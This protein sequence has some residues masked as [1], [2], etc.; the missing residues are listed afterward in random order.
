MKELLRKITPR[1]LI[2]IKHYI[3]I[4]FHYHRETPALAKELSK[5]TGIPYLTLWLEMNM[6]I[7]RFVTPDEYK[8]YRFYDRSR[9]SRN[10]IITKYRMGH[11]E[12]A[13]NQ[14]RS[15]VKSSILSEK[16]RYYPV[17][18][19]YIGRQWL[20]APDA[21]DHQI[22]EFLCV[23]KQ[24]IL[25]PSDLGKGVGVRKVFHSDVTDIKAF[26]EA[27]KKERLL[28][29]EVVKQHPDIDA[30]NSTSVNTI[31]INTV[32]DKAGIPHIMCATLRIGTGQSIT[33]NLSGSG[34]VASIDLDSG[35][36]FTRAINADLQ[37][38][39]KH[40]TSHVT[41]PGFQLPHWKATKEMVTCAAK[42][43][44]QTRWIGWDIAVSE[45]EPLVIEA[46]TG[47]GARVMQLSS[48]VGVYHDFLRYL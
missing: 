39:I 26:C 24:L 16:H 17:L 18:S 45:K 13:F 14:Q 21:S 12:T 15:A 37:V 25:K 2:W 34:I 19:K 28:L 4:Y 27:A 35:V 48:Q 47:A 31:R 33:D 8:I 40:P 1:F 23:Q 32:M 6:A 46:N 10:Q 29:E 43:I 44:P 20:Y 36:V 11:L 30:I 42:M 9:R 3:Q 5:E 7:F 22:E 38:Y 41:I